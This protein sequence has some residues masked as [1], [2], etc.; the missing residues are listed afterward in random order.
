MLLNYNFTI[1]YI[2][3]KDFGQ[4]DALSRLATI[5]DTGGL[6]NRLTCDRLYE[7]RKLAQI[8]PPFSSVALLQ[9]QK[10]VIPNSLRHRVLSTLHKAHPGQTRVKMLARSFVY[11][12][13]MDSDIEILVKT[14]RRCAFV[15][16]D[17]IKAELQSWRKPHQPWTRVHA[18]FA[19]PMEGLYYPL[20]VD[21]YPKWPEIVQISSMCHCH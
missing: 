2:N 19:G 14:C 11:W 10:A 1:E 8:Q 12:P 21:A 17:S 18:D 9:Q 16:K 15:A 5:I 3:T 4:V 13:T 20:I 6:R 7:A